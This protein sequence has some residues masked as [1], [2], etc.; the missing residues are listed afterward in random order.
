MNPLG[1]FFIGRRGSSPFT[2]RNRNTPV[3]KTFC[4]PPTRNSGLPDVRPGRSRAAQPR[5]TRGLVYLLF[6]LLCHSSRQLSLGVQLAVKPSLM[7]SAVEWSSVCYFQEILYHPLW[8]RQN[9][10]QA[11][12]PSLVSRCSYIHVLLVAMS[13]C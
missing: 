12:L 9:S 5:Q 6:S 7:P 4:H 3:S 2:H 11:S 10:F 13:H 8:S 1:W